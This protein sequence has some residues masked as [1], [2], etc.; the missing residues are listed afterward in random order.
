M[1]RLIIAI[2]FLF[3]VIRWTMILFAVA[4]VLALFAFTNIAPRMHEGASVFFFV[5]LVATLVSLFVELKQEIPE[6]LDYFE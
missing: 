5:F 6:E 4:I 1:L 3:D 2:R